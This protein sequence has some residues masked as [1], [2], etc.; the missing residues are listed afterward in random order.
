VSVNRILGNCDWLTNL[1]HAK[2]GGLTEPCPVLW[3]RDAYKFTIAGLIRM[4]GATAI[5]NLERTLGLPQSHPQIG[6]FGMI[7]ALIRDCMETCIF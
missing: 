7:T 4:A 5:E 6:A 3:I 1:P 2:S